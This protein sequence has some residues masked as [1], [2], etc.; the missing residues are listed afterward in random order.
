[1]WTLF[2]DSITWAI[3]AAVCST[4]AVVG[5]RLHERMK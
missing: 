3:L 1:M 5:Y 4:L 2:V